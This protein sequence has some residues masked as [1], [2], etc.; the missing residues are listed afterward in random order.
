[1]VG[2]RAVHILLECFLVYYGDRRNTLSGTRAHL[3]F[4]VNT[5]TDLYYITTFFS[6]SCSSKT[7]K[8]GSFGF[9]AIHML[10]SDDKD[11]EQTRMHLSGMRTARS[12]PYGGS[13]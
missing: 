6:H 2:K 8:A 5:N 13:P 1:M 12:L 4:G 9:I 10:F 11:Q 3:L 7:F